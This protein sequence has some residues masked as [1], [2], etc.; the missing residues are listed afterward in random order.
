ML[1]LRNN[2]PLVQ[3]NP[4]KPRCI[5]CCVNC[6]RSAARAQPPPARSLKQRSLTACQT[7]S[8]RQFREPSSHVHTAMLISARTLGFRC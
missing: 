6:C 7:A 4:S 1:P 8:R 3:G 5:T 2:Q